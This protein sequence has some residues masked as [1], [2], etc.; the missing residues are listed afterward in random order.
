MK[1]VQFP[2][3]TPGRPAPD[4][5][6]LG[7]MIRLIRMQRRRKKIIS[8]NRTHFLTIP[9]TGQHLPA[10]R[11]KGGIRKT[12]VF[13]NDSLFF[14]LKKPGNRFADCATAAKIFVTQQR[15]DVTI[16]VDL[17]QNGPGSRAK[18]PLSSFFGARSVRSHIQLCWPAF[19]NRREHP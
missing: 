15:L 8:R 5:G 16:P 13:E 6:I 18:L 7:K 14:L 1:V 19:A 10:K 11:K 4:L 3:T 9:E 17:I 12:I 2:K